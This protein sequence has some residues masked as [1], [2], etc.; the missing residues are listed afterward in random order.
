MEF[1]NGSLMIPAQ[2]TS[3]RFREEAR[4]ANK[5]DFVDLI[6]DA[7]RQNW[8]RNQRVLA[9]VRTAPATE[10]VQKRKLLGNWPPARF[11][12]WRLENLTPWKLSVKS[13]TF[14]DWN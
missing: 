11:A 6:S 10:K 4:V 9:E 2:T 14:K 13:W 7:T 3:T 1:G 12:Q 8:R 5:P